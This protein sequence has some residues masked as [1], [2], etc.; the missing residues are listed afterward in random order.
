MLENAR[1]TAFT[2][3]EILTENQQG[4]GGRAKITNISLHP[5]PLPQSR[6]GLSRNSVSKI[7]WHLS[8]NLAFKN[9]FKN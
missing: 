1:V 6:L 7:K 5:Q 4:G 8:E 9:L 2:A 3:F